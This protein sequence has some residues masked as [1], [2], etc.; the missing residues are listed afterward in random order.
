VATLKLCA[1]SSLALVGACDANRL[2][3]RIT[4]PGLL[5]EAP[6][7]SL[8]V[9]LPLAW[10]ADAAPGLEVAF[11]LEGVSPAGARRESERFLVADGQASW[12]RDLAPDP[13]GLYTLHADVYDGA[14]RLDTFDGGQQVMLPGVIFREAGH[15]FAGSTQDKDVWLI[16]ASLA[17]MTVSIRVYDVADRQVASL[18]DTVIASDLAPIGRVFAWD[19]ALPAGRYDLEAFVHEPFGSGRVDSRSQVIW[20]PA[21]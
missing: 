21:D 20:R 7:N 3:F 15:D 16:A 14:E 19:T 8:G 11:R 4:E 12:F 10:E 2:D 1:L 5:S 18:G 17:Q 6:R 9:Q 13:I